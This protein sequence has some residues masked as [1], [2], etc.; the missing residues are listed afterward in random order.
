MR[1][2]DWIGKNPISGIYKEGTHRIL[3]V[4]SCP[5]EDQKADEIIATI[6][7]CFVRSRFVF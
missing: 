2:L 1:Y 7:V 6:R 4:D 3:P 5:I